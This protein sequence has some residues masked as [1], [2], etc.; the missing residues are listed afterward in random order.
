M[1]DLLEN[2]VFI[3]VAVLGLLMLLFPDKYLRASI[4]EKKSG[5]LIGRIL[6]AVLMVGGIGLFV[7][8]IQQ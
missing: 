6:G 5:K 2:A 8:F 1:Y 4:R 7:Y 3:C